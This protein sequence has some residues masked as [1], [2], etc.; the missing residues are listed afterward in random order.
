M[1]ELRLDYS[2]LTRT[3]MGL[4]DNDCSS[5]YDRILIPISSLIARGMGIHRNAVLVHANTLE[6]AQYKLKLGKQT[7]ADSYTNCAMWPL[8]GSGQGSANSPT[9]WC[10]IS[11][12]LFQAHES[13][14]FGMKMQTP[15]GDVTLKVNMVGF[16]DD[17]TCVTAGDPT[18][19]LQDLITRMQHDAQLWNDIL[20]SSGGK[21]ELSKCGYHTSY[22]IFNP[23][24]TPVLYQEQQNTSF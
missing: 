23:D 8:H 3:P 9:I 12:K 19:P 24:G 15:F 2:A 5:C 20:W 4:F 11:S 18:A 13:Q 14:A 10:F 16:V 21:L 1:E 17:A 6:Q 7:S 22:Y